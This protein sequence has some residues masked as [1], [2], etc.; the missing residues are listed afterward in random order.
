[1]QSKKNHIKKSIIT[2]LLL[3]ALS[4][5]AAF[6]KPQPN[7]WCKK[8]E[9]QCI[10]SIVG[11]EERD[12][13]DE[14]FYD[15]LMR[16]M[17]YQRDPQLAKKRR[18]AFKIINTV[19]FNSIDANTVLD[20]QMT[21][22]DLQLFCGQPD[23]PATTLLHHI[24][25]TSTELGRA[26]LA[27]ML[28]Q[29]STDHELLKRRQQTIE[30]LATNQELY[31]QLKLVLKAFSLIEP[32]FLSFWTKDQL[33][34]ASE[35]HYYSFP[36]QVQKLTNFLNNNALALDI[37]SVLE[38][39]KRI[40]WCGSTSIAAG[41]L[42]TYGTLQ[43]AQ[44]THY[45]PTLLE[46]AAKEL[47]GSGGPTLAL[48][49]MIADNNM[50]RGFAGLI[51]GA[52]CA[53]TAKEDFEWARDHII[54]DMCLQEKMMAVSAGLK[55]L[56]V[57]NEH[58]KLHPQIRATLRYADGLEDVLLHK[59]TRMPNFKHL[60]WLLKT[61]TLHG[62]PSAFSRTGRVLIAYSL[63]HELKYEWAPALAAL[64]ELDAYMSMATLYREYREQPCHYTLVD[65]VAADKPAIAM[66]DFWNPFIPA[67]KA[68]TN[69]LVVGGYKRPNIIITG[70]N[71]GGKSTLLRAIGSNILLAQTFG[72]AAA[73]QMSI[74]PFDTIATYF[75]ITDDIAAG[76][77]MF[78]AEAMRAH[79][80][81]KKVEQAKEHGFSFVIAD[82]LFKGSSPREEEAAAY[83]VAN[84][85]GTFDTGIAI[86][87]THFPL[88]TLLAQHTTTFDNYCVSV[89]IEPDG[90]LNYPFKLTP[91]VSDQHIALDVLREQGFVSSILDQA[92]KI[93]TTDK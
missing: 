26:M 67:Q 36:D 37:K 78:K 31:D 19:V 53:L 13:P 61:S 46:K 2:F 54:L 84:Y 79:Y 16:S 75:N 5:A 71:A 32:L 1:M 11:E 83:S 69:T 14:S 49:T 82:E 63:M 72:I 65:F 51:A 58:L 38:H 34:H 64:A 4:A 25:H 88:L 45:A 80:L 9:R 93:V 52:Y 27:C 89:A 87:A 66:H 23:A 62:A 33:R 21:W 60:I 20:D 90:S 40:L 57:I 42:P 50:V 10:A 44:A 41:V 81:I 8:V 30:L 17:A 3:P 6:Q 39:A 77:S 48:I 85:L 7:S 86:I 70:P 24:N 22:Q 12:W 91:G 73:S 18:C 43:M 92:K 35:R 29:P 76:K 68:V 28:V 74:T 55:S 56:T 59:A 47:K 15:F